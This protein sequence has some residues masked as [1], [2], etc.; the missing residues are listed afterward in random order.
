MLAE[1]TV[2]M[3]YSFS[4]IQHNHLPMITYI[5]RNDAIQ[6]GI[7]TEVPGSNGSPAA[8]HTIAR[9]GRSSAE[10]LCLLELD[11]FAKISSAPIAVAGAGFHL[12]MVR[13]FGWN[14]PLSSGLQ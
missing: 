8:R 12:R 5:H 14:L 7:I 9:S 4:H 1:R 13:D 10:Q 6:T 2:V 3:D 11:P